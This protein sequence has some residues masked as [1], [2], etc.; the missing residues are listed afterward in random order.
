MFTI[1]PDITDVQ[2]KEKDLVK[3]IFSINTHDVATP[4]MAHERAS[5]YVIFVREG[6]ARLSAYVGLFLLTTERKLF[7]KHSSNPFLSEEVQGVE[8]EARSFVEDLGALLDEIDLTKMSESDKEL[9]IYEQSIFSEKKHQ[10]PEPEPDVPSETNEQSSAQEG[11]SAEQPQQA[12][13]ESPASPVQPGPVVPVPE[14]AAAPVQPA[15]VVHAAPPVLEPAT[16]SVQPAQVVQPSPALASVAA[17]TLPV[18]TV[19]PAPA[20]ES[21]AAQTQEA[22]APAAPVVSE[23]PAQISQSQQA[24]LEVLDADKAALL[25][26]SAK[27]RHDII[28]KS[29]QTH[30]AKMLKQPPKKEPL[31]PTSVVSRD[32]EALSRLLTSF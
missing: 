24:S 20:P 31:S 23:P 9:W 27:K 11:A 17:P 1:D 5:S 25:A 21:M 32:R 13:P 19:Q 15:P 2:L 29:V 6:K 26:E 30:N 16:A 14:P 22:V 12:A 28:Q 4:E 3:V 7:Y 10:A 8:D 18:Q